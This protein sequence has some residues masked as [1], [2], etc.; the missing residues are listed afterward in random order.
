MESKNA[1]EKINTNN[2]KGESCAVLITTFAY[3][4]SF[5]I[6]ANNTKKPISATNALLFSNTSFYECRDSID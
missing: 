1:C 4:I 6:V 2:P 3:K 5:I